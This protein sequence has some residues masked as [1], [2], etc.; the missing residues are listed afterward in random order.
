MDA[1]LC[2]DRKC[3]HRHAY[4]VDIVFA[5]HNHG[6]PCDWISTSYNGRE[7][8][9]NLYERQSTKTKDG[10]DRIDPVGEDE[11]T[12]DRRHL[13]ELA[14]RRHPSDKLLGTRPEKA[15]TAMQDLM[16]NYGTYPANAE[17]QR[18]RGLIKGKIPRSMR[19]L[20]GS[21]YH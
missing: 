13:R 17:L 18:C 10:Y 4:A 5:V 21:S 15:W 3:A 7:V 20:A 9:K 8:P 1:E 16:Q 6:P 12:V 19:L 2:R 14:G 11:V